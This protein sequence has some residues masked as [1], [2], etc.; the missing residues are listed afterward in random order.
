MM[1]MINHFLLYLT[2]RNKNPKLW[3]EKNPTPEKVLSLAIYRGSSTELFSSPGIL[4]F[5]KLYNMY[6]FAHSRILILHLSLCI[7]SRRMIIG[8]CSTRPNG[9][10]VQVRLPS[11]QADV[12]KDG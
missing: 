5:Y 12:Q 10:F 11:Y 2:G 1:M 8:D 6:I 9:I 7:A 3:R 4:L